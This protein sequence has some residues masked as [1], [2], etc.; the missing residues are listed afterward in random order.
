VLYYASLNALPIMA[1][2]VLLSGE[3]R[4]YHD[5]PHHLLHQLGG[6]TPLLVWAA[7]VAWTETALTGTLVWCTEC[8]SGLTTAIVGVRGSLAFLPLPPHL[9]CSRR[10]PSSISPPLIRCSRA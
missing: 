8:N 6:A 5:L 9:P 10:N 3:L 1:L 7:A 4:T 2:A